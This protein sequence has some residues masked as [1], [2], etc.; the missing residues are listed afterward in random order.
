M[1]L[2]HT[3]TQAYKEVESSAAMKSVKDLKDK[4]VQDM[5]KTRL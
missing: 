1:Y 4:L 2:S 5:K 3:Q